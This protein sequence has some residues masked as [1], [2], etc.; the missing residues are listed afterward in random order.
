[1]TWAPE[2]EAHR[3]VT[4]EVAT[5]CPET[6]TEATLPRAQE[7]LEPQQ[8]EAAEGAWPRPGGRDAGLAASELWE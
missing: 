4:E 5:T 3:H 7:H 6:E 2:G 1:M 8:L